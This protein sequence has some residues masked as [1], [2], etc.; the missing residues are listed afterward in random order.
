MPVG[1]SGINVH[2]LQNL[3][4][5]VEVR[6]IVLTETTR[7]SHALLKVFVSPP[8]VST[9][10][11]AAPGELPGHSS[12]ESGAVLV[13]GYVIDPDE[14][15]GAGGYRVLRRK[16]ML[17]PDSAVMDNKILRDKTSV[18]VIIGGIIISNIGS[19]VG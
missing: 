3:I 12:G 10:C 1:C 4:R 11:D 17:Q 14:I 18:V 19:R 6:S 5:A 13:I 7:Q 15:S 16:G 8:P 9:P 2:R